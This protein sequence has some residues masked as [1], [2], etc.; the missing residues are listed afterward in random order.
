[1]SDFILI[2]LLSPVVLFIFLKISVKALTFKKLLSQ[3]NIT[4]LGA[5]LLTSLLFFNFLPHSLE[6]LSPR[7]FSVVALISLTLFLLIET[8]LIPILNF[9]KI[10][11][12]LK[13]DKE[14]SCS[15]YHQHHHH[16]SHKGNFSAIGCLLVC[17][18]FDGIR[19]GSAFLIDT[20][21]S[22]TTSLGLLF[23]ILPE[24]FSVMALAAHLPKK[25]IMIIQLTLCLLLGLG[26]LS[27]GLVQMAL[28]H[29]IVLALASAAFIHIV[30]LH[31]LPLSLQKEN[32]KWF[33]SSLALSSVLLLFLH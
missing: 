9:S 6:G 33:F 18:F 22:L 3:G 21:A 19:L 30:F 10:I 24:A 7:E 17:S 15:H 11:P 13:Q 28:S 32:Q 20:A 31:L 2:G 5:G 4:A 23:H 25:K 26:I 14:S 1:M 8:Y 12:Q 27:T 29:H 16:F